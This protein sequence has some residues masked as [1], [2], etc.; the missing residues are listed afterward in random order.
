MADQRAGVEAGQFF[1]AN[2]EGDDGNVLGLDALV[3]E[4]LVERHVGV[5]VDGRDDGSLLA[6]GAEFLDVGDDGLPIGMTEWRVVDHDVFLADAFATSDRPGGS[7]WWSRIDIVG[8]GEHPALHRAAILAHQII[9]GGDRLLVRRGA[10]VEYVALAFLALILHRDRRAGCSSSSKTGSTDLRDT[11]VQQPNTAETLSF[12]ISR[13]P[14]RQ[15]AASPKRDRPR[16]LRVSCRGR[17]PSCS[18]RR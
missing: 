4:L 5:A 10:C 7:C 16:P 15:K 8:A 11:E 9:D 1:L 3:A 13:G 17:R 18:A 12:E 6:G 2:R 14:F